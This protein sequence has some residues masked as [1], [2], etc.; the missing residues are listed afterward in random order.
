MYL[1]A[2]DYWLNHVFNPTSTKAA[3]AA[4]EAFWPIFASSPSRTL[5]V[6]ILDSGIRVPEEALLEPL[7]GLRGETI[8]VLLPWPEGSA[9]SGNFDEA[10]FTV[11]RPKGEER[12]LELNFEAGGYTGTFFQPV[13]L[14]SARID[15]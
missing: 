12:M 3:E 15:Q 14:I 7:T 2:S 5:I 9:M 8:E 10:E 13:L 4:W 1:P 11:A 6:D